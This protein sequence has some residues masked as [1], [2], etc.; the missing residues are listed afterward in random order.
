MSTNQISSLNTLP[1]EVILYIFRY[2]DAQTIVRSFRTICKR[3][4]VIVNTYNQLNFDFNGISKS[5]FHFLC[6][7]VQP[8]NVEL[9]T[10]SDS[11]E[12]PGQIEH[13]LSIFRINQFIRLRSLTLLEI[14]DCYLTSIL[15]N[16]QISTLSSLSICSCRYYSENKNCS[17]ALSSA[18]S[19]LNLHKFS[20]NIPSFDA[21]KIT[22]P[23]EC[24]IQHLEICCRTLD[25]YCNILYCLPNLRTFVVE[26]LSEDDLDEAIPKLSNLDPFY[27]LVSLTFKYCSIDMIILESILSLVPSLEHLQLMRSVDLHNFV[28]HV[29]QWEKLVSTKLISLTKFDCFLIAKRHYFDTPTDTESLIAPF[30]ASFWTKTKGWLIIC[31]H[32]VSSQTVILYTPPIFDPQFEF[33]YESKEIRRSTSVPTMNDKILMSGVRKMSL[34]LTNVM[35]S[36]TSS[37]VRLT[38][39]FFISRQR[40]MFSVEQFGPE[41]FLDDFI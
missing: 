19:S 29:H 8:K 4:Y 31:D 33:I 25:E 10:L 40:H 41:N 13:F 12:T 22:W 9:L 38:I 11:D 18:I 27:Q 7:Y 6:N 20:F 35:C 23:L 3:F 34:D 26:Y 5:D 28:S 21:S 1:V 37:Q 36:A 32:I 15:N 24:T 16:L 17:D 14:D 2:F 30:R 39:D